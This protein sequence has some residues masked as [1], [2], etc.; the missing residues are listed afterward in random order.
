MERVAES[1]AYIRT[2]PSRYAGAIV[3]EKKLLAGRMP[4]G[5]DRRDLRNKRGNGPSPNQK[6]AGKKKRGR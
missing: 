2:T 1:K 6:A 4:R 5:T 3:E